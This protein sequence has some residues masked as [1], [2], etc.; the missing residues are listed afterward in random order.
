MAIT[1]EQ[2]E[3]LLS[4]LADKLK[5]K[6][7]EIFLQQAEISVLKN[8]LKEAEALLPKKTTLEIR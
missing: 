6:D 5:E 8:K 7:N 4:A 1:K 2:Y 3:I